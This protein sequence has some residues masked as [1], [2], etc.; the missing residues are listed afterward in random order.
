MAPRK[1]T[2][3]AAAIAPVETSL[4]GS[5]VAATAAGHVFFTSEADRATLNPAFIEVNSTMVDT[6]GKMATR[7]SAAGIAS[8]APPVVETVAETTKAKP[9]ISA[10]VATAISRPKK[11]KRGGHIKPIYP[12]ESMEV[13]HSFFVEATAEN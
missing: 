3:Q 11:G 7:A 4:L 12:F 10:I 6:Q 13:N 9:I 8:L 5:I 2:A 1:K